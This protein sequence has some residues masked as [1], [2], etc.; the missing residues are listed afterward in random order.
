MINCRYEVGDGGAIEYSQRDKKSVDYQI[1]LT[2]V[3]ETINTLRDYKKVAMMLGLAEQ[4][5]LGMMKGH[6]LDMGSGYGGLAISLFAIGLF[7]PFT[8]TAE[9]DLRVW[10]VNPN[11]TNKN[12]QEP[13][14]RLKR[15]FRSDFIAGLPLETIAQGLQAH[16]MLSIPLL[17]YDL[18]PFPDGFF[19]TIVDNLA[20]FHH[21]PLTQQQFK[22]SIYEYL[23]VLKSGGMAVMGPLVA[24]KGYDKRKVEIVCEVAIEIGAEVMVFADKQFKS[25]SSLV[26]H[27]H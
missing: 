5:F 12:F 15:M 4:E 7:N 3:A 1:G 23:R 17:S 6:V 24:F 19:N 2:S 11:Y 14:E 9:N 26:I 21:C 25:T 16:D 27:K 13:P 18:S 10:S 8:S 22:R 20:V